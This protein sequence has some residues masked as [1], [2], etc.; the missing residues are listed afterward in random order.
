M[1]KNDAL[2][3][4]NADVD[5]DVLPDLEVLF[6]VRKSK[7]EFYSRE[8]VRRALDDKKLAS[9]LGLRVVGIQVNLNFKMNFTKSH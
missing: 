4:V 3:D 7:T 5:N 9:E 8:K 2:D 1:H 6:A